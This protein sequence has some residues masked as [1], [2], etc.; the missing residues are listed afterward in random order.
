MYGSNMPQ[1]G[2]RSSSTSNQDRWVPLARPRYC[3][4]TH[5]ASL[6]PCHQCRADRQELTGVES[7]TDNTQC[8]APSGDGCKQCRLGMRDRRGCAAPQSA[9]NRHR[10]SHR[11]TVCTHSQHV[12]I[13]TLS[14]T[15]WIWKSSLFFLHFSHRLSA[16]PLSRNSVL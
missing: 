10:S 16:S 1:A 3:H 11:S 9:Y 6:A 13:I 15:Q 2:H 4:P 14:G 5:T 12:N 8:T 7:N